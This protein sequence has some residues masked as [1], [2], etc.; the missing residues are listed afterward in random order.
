MA[1]IMISTGIASLWSRSL[2]YVG[3]SSALL[4]S[5]GLH[6]GE[7]PDICFNVLEQTKCCWINSVVEDHPCSVCRWDKVVVVVVSCTYTSAQPTWTYQIYRYIQIYCMWE[8]NTTFSLKHCRQ[9]TLS[10]LPI[11]TNLPQKRFWN[12][13]LYIIQWTIKH[14]MDFVFSLIWI[15]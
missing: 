15:T 12:T 4:D 9:R 6:G 8:K 2:I 5:T 13:T 14:N 11:S 3:L 7:F 1:I 10:P